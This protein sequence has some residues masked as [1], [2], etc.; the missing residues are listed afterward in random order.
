MAGTQIFPNWVDDKFQ[1]WD[2]DRHEL[3]GY[4][5][6]NLRG[7]DSKLKAGRRG[8]L[9]YENPNYDVTDILSIPQTYVEFKVLHVYS[10]L[11]FKV[12]LLWN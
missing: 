3:G 4:I 9:T 11:S 2:Q 8:Y 7:H 1:I 5:A 6:I 12:K 10:P